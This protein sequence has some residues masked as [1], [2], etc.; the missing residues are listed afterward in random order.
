MI[1]ISAHKDTVFNNPKMDY[2]DGKHIGLL[3]NQIGI[4]VANLSLYSNDIIYELE[5]SGKIQYYF[6]EGEEFGLLTNPP[7]LT[8]KDIVIVVDVCSD[9]KYKGY[10]VAIENIWN[11]ED[12]DGIIENLKWEGYKVLKSDYTGDLSDEDEAF[13]WVEQK[14]PVMSFIIPIEAINDG[15]HRIQQDNTITYQKVKKAANCLT[16]LICYTI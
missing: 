1:L 4:L 14:V 2:K 13:S 12:I 11:I 6:N 3:D 9:K 8:K 10:D 7:K 5:K 15:W 16:R